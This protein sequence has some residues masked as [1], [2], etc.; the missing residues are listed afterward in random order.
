MTT[1]FCIRIVFKKAQVSAKFHCN[2]ST[3]TL[4]SEDGEGRIHSSTVIESHKRPANSGG[5]IVHNYPYYVRCRG[6]MPRVLLLFLF[7]CPVQNLS[8]YQKQIGDRGSSCRTPLDMLQNSGMRPLLHTEL[9][10]TFFYEASFNSV[11]CFFEIYYHSPINRP[12]RKPFCGG[13]MIFGRLFFN[14][15]A[16]T[17]EA[18]L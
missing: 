16:I 6:W 18:I 13:L 7:Y 17:A 10:E 9:F 8:N 1:K 2:T 11:N 12:L 14:L 3:I 5:N 4:F 15:S